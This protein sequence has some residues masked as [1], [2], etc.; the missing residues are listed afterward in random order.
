MLT[1]LEFRRLLLSDWRFFPKILYRFASELAWLARE[2]RLFSK[3]TVDGLNSPDSRTE[4]RL[5]EEY[6]LWL[7]ISRARSIFKLVLGGA[8]TRFNFAGFSL[9][10]PILVNICRLTQSSTWSSL[11]LPCSFCFLNFSL[12]SL[13]NSASSSTLSY[14]CWHT[15]FYTVF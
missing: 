12:K 2:S 6:C 5:S 10:S 7:C 15:A 9:F 3:L 13:T 1:T 8:S 4:M 14:L 11:I